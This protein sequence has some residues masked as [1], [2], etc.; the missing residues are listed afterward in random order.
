MTTKRN[1]TIYDV[2]KAA[3]VSHQTV[4]RV[5]NNSSSIRQSTRE[6]V[7]L[8][9]KELGYIPSAA[10]RALVTSKSKII[11]VLMTETGTNGP[12]SLLHA[13][14]EEAHS[15]GYFAV[16]ISVDPETESSVTE[17]LQQLQKL[18]AEGLIVI[19]PQANIMKVIEK[20]SFAFRVVYL[21]KLSGSSRLTASVDSYH[22][23]RNATAHLIGLGHSKLLHLAGPSSWFEAEV[24]KQGFI[25]ECAAAKVSG[26]VAAADWSIAKGY[27]L[28]LE[29]TK[30]S[31]TAIVAANDHLALGLLKAFSERGIAVPEDVSIIGFDDIPEAA[32]LIPTL[33]TLRPNFAEIGRVAMGLVLGKLSVEQVA[34]NADLLPEL[35]IRNSTTKP[36][37]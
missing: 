2:A 32:Y 4:S 17:G 10:A 29:F 33:T 11:G 12:A 9:M 27:E 34:K 16:A 25:D 28:G 37:K 35:I 22:A 31:F 6:R 15:E 14:Q 23:V 30:G 1:A 3:A 36:A 19:A 20:S 18:A 7:L 13:M 8:A 24:R 26:K 21:D 5:I